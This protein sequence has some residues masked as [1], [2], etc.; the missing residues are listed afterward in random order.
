MGFTP[1]QLA[2]MMAHRA[3]TQ[4]PPTYPRKG[5]LLTPSND[6]SIPRESWGANEWKA[7]ALFLEEMGGMMARR[8]RRTEKELRHARTKLARRRKPVSFPNWLDDPPTP[9]KR[10]RKPADHTRQIAESVLAIRAEF[11]GLGKKLTDRQALEEHYRRMGKRA[12]RA[13]EK[14]AGHILNVVSQLRK[15]HVNLTS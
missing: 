12:L 1:F 2:A 14:P 3:E 13:S 8:L 10:G 9:K 7:Y 5:T 15:R 4:W 6:P 11:A